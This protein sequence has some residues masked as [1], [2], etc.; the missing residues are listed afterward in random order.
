MRV[1]FK[2]REETAGITGSNKNHFV[3]CAVEFGEEEK[4][5][6]AARDLK[7]T[8]FTVPSGSPLPTQSAFLASGILN[9]I[10]RFGVMF[11]ILFGII[12]SFT[13]STGLSAV[14]SLLFFGGGLLWIGAAIAGRSQNKAIDN[15]EQTITLG[16]L[17][18]HGQFTCL[19]ANPAYAKSLEADIKEHLTNVKAIL[20]DSAELQ[21]ESTFEL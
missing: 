8:N 3:D 7:D 20:K 17:L 16:K 13:N 21:K 15:P 14:A 6:I 18:A 19:A 10:G 1:T 4:A 9:S 11:G 2:H 12:S 5:I